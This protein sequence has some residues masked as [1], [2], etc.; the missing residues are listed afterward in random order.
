M[1][2]ELTLTANKSVTV[3]NLKDYA[4]FVRNNTGAVQ[5]IFEF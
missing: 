3:T 1:W 4:I 5:K 2:I